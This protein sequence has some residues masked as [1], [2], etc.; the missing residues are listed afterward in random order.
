MG[1]F[2]ASLLF[3]SWRLGE[4]C[5]CEKGSGGRCKVFSGGL[6]AGCRCA[7]SCA[8]RA[9]AGFSP[10]YSAL[11]CGG[12]RPPETEILHSDSGAAA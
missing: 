10:M 5:R 11:P 4:T 3:S 8:S 12:T 1:C 2:S 7:L 6:A 9:G